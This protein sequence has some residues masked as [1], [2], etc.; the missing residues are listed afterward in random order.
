MPKIKDLGI[1]VIPGTMRPPEI[2]GGGGCGQSC[3]QSCRN[4]TAHFDTDQHVVCL[5]ADPGGCHHCQPTIP[6]RGHW[7]GADTDVLE[8]LTAPACNPCLP[9]TFKP[10][11]AMAAMHGGDTD[12]AG[13]CLTAPVCNPCLPGTF[14]PK[15]AMGMAM[16]G[17]WDDTDVGGCLTAPGDPNCV[18]NQPSDCGCTNDPMTFGFIG[19]A[20]GTQCLP[21]ACPGGSHCTA[22]S[23]TVTI[24]PNT[25]RLTPGTLTRD[26]IAAI[27]TQLKEYLDN[28]DAAEKELLPKTLEGVESREKE[29]QAELE[30]LK[31]RRSE[32]KKS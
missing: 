22:G 29:L 7:Y 4:H 25:P 23:L 15:A 14:R 18:C 31:A 5:T 8:C 1:N 21:T 28:V 13:G 32:L 30:Q 6:Q 2:G 10:K 11:P 27:R 24:T 19:C 3:N 17:G 16:V 12:H 9:G 26:H 20:R